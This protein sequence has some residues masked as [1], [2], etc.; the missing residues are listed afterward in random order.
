M[1][2]KGI[3][4]ERKFLLKTIPSHLSKPVEI[5]QGYF[6]NVPFRVRINL[7]SDKTDLTV[8]NI[9]VAYIGF[10]HPAGGSEY[11]EEVESLIDP[12]IAI[13][14]LNDCGERVI[15]KTRKYKYIDGNKWEIDF[16]H[17]K[18][19]GL[20]VAEF[21]FVKNDDKTPVTPDFIGKEVTNDERYSNYLLSL[22]ENVEGLL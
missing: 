19:E 10:K 12:K 3:E 7:F 4:R 22:A 18:L 16:F 17:G 20:V 11:R 9:K 14:L 1:S 21:E 2:D 5:F 6:G 13:A 8:E 15:H